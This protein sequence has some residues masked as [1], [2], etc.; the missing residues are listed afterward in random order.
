[1]P[2][3]TID[4]RQ[5][6]FKPG[7]NLVDAAKRAGISIPVF[8]YHPGLTVVAQC[9][10]C[11]VEVQGIKKIQ[12]ACSTKAAEG[13]VV[14][15]TS[16]AAKQARQSV[17]EF[18]LI[19]HPLDCPICDRSGDCDLQDNSY[20]HGGAY[21][22]YT[23]ERRTYMDLDMG[24]VIKKNMN[25]CIHCTRCIR[26]GAEVAGV[27]EMVAL[28]RSNNTEIT[29]L[30]GRPLET[31]YAGNY[32]DIC[33][34]GSLTLKDFRFKK[35]AWMVKKAQTVCEGCSKGCNIELHWD[36][37]TVY[38]TL[39]REN[40]AVNKW[41]IC[42]EGR[43]N[44]HYIHDENRIVAPV[45][46]KGSGMEEKS[47]SEVV[48]AA[49]DALKGKKVEILVGSDL[50]LEEAKMIQAFCRDMFPG[51]PI[52]HFGTPGIK[53]SKDDGD[54]DKILKRKSKTSNLHGMEKLGIQPFSGLGKDAAALVFR[55]GRAVVPD[56]GSALVVGVGVF[57][58]PQAAKFEAVLPG[59]SFAEK[60]GTIVNSAGME[61]KLVRAVLPPGESRQ[62]SEILM[63][64]S[65]GGKGAGVA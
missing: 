55:G 65:R 18:L 60:D 54:A 53:T 64:L 24:P 27:R 28:Q 41:W 43:F 26:F 15:T 2:T 48:G 50:T 29:T 19:N 31:D 14:S 63:M 33:P 1:M 61:Q 37:N 46:R 3:C 4:G 56:L 47:W 7:E 52:S 13:M 51:A 12:T 6:E 39:P 21:M 22:R 25:R 38:R 9:R 17:M 8:C 58:K 57:L 35:R 59:A 42:D 10:M 20:G 40:Q 36:G 5:V 49:R 16:E 45:T 30:D 44:F 62:V 32:A 11:A 23:E 34:T